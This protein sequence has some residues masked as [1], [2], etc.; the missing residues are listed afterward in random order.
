MSI[1]TLNVYPSIM[2][3]DPRISGFKYFLA[4]PDS[5]TQTT[6]QL[7]SYL[8]YVIPSSHPMKGQKVY[9]STKSLQKKLNIDDWLSD[10]E[11]SQ[12]VNRKKSINFL[13][14]K[15]V[16]QLLVRFTDKKDRKQIKAMCK[17][18]GHLDLVVAFSEPKRDI[19]AMFKH[20]RMF[21]RMITPMT[22]LTLRKSRVKKLCENIGFIN[23]LKILSIPG[24]EKKKMLRTFN[25]IAKDQEKDL[26]APL[27]GK[28]QRRPNT[29]E[30]LNYGYTLT[31]KAMYVRFG[32]LGE[33]VY[34]KV[35]DTFELVNGISFATYMVKATPKL[36]VKNFLWENTLLQF[37]SKKQINNIQEPCLFTYSTLE[38]KVV[39]ITRKLAGD[40]SSLN[41]N[42]PIIYS[43]ILDVLL[44]LSELHK[45]G[46]VHNDIKPGN[47]FIL[48][49]SKG[50]FKKALL[51]DFG[52]GTTVT[53]ARRFCFGSMLYSPPEYKFWNDTGKINP[54]PSRDVYAV[55][56]SIIELL[57]DYQPTDPSACFQ[58]INDI[59]E[60]KKIV[61]GYFSKDSK[62][63]SRMDLLKKCMLVVATDLIHPEENQRST[64][65]EA[66]M[67]WEMIG[68]LFKDLIS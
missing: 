28:V 46:F 40:I 52:F 7:A 48:K 56:T 37:F 53:Q 26:S 65:H 55:G 16:D 58:K 50:G 5:E 66:L 20:I 14:I 24:V 45:A 63:F 41:I 25:L 30:K 33:G 51:G 29:K 23:A 18:I 4:N 39:G 42:V 49:N 31:E 2:E 35:R 68:D 9:I 64:S 3:S 12:R 38:G 60:I 10:R 15:I 34:K 44:G 11:I 17:K 54:Y 1:T 59:K 61:Y 47:I 67:R 36:A 8:P 19:P 22:P 43:I 62:S 32:H 27:H 21:A 6:D 13:F 57:T